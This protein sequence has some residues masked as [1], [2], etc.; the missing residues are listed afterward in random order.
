MF[1]PFLIMLREGLEDAVRAAS[2]AI[3]DVL[4]RAGIL[5]PDAPGQRY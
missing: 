5:T 1:I 4:E 3:R 2:A